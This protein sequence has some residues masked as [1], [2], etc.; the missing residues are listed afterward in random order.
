MLALR[1]L[2]SH[3]FKLT[4][5]QSTVEATASAA[6]NALAGDALPATSIPAKK[7]RARSLRTSRSKIS[8][9]NPRQWKRP[10]A[11][12]VLPVFDEALKYIKADSVKLKEEMK[13]LQTSLEAAK[14]TSEPDVQALKQMEEKLE[15]L[16]INSE[17]NFPEVQ[18]KCANGMADL[19]KPVDRHIIERRWRKEGPL[20]LLMERLHQMHIVPDVLAGLHPSLDLRITFP[21]HHVKTDARKKYRHVEPGVYLLPEQTVNPPRLYTDVF[22][23]DERLY[24][25]I[26]VDPDVPDVANSTYGT[27]LHWLQ[28]NISLSATTP[29]PISDINTHTQYIP[30]HPQKG[31]PYHRYTLLLLRQKTTLDIPPFTAEERL[32]FSMRDF[33]E[34]YDLDITAGGAHMW[35]E[36]W[37]AGVSDIFRDVLKLD[38]PQFGKPPKVDR[39]AGKNRYML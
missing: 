1:R 29:V 3:S 16:E 21:D 5:A 6:S 23:T 9:E 15:I 35:R 18:W 4:R 27:F 30:P 10:L 24:T 38:E 28:P 19:S 34:N 11:V 7:R 20:D 8:L 31:T 25:L 2:Q 36:V 37:S 12:G 33:I 22:H 17:I 14:Q 32:G 13:E 26:M 39:Y